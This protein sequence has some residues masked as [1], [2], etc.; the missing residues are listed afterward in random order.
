MTIDDC[1]SLSCRYK[2]AL[3]KIIVFLSRETNPGIYG[4]VH[5]TVL[6]IRDL[7][8]PFRNETILYT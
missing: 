2:L 3:L 7:F 1:K 6:F 8:R 4:M 5:Y